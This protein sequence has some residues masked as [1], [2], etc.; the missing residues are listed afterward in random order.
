MMTVHPFRPSL[1]PGHLSR[2][3]RRHARRLA[4]TY[5]LVAW[6]GLDLAPMPANAQVTADAVQPGVGQI[7]NISPQVLRYRLRRANGPS[8]TRELELAPGQYHE[9]RRPTSGHSDLFG[10]T[11]G[12]VGEGFV[13]I[14]YPSLSGQVRF[15]LTA[16]STSNEQELMPFWFYVHDAS[17]NGWMIQAPNVESARQVQERLQQQPVMTREEREVLEYQLRSN[18]ALYR[19]R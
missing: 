2:N 11:Q 10:V 6:V 12:K 16:R 15:K 8:W 13:V 19:P 17:G 18:H 1:K 9:Y 14:Q 5:L 7:W 4:I 3:P